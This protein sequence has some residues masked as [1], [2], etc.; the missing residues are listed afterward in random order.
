M[1]FQEALGWMKRGEKIKRAHWK[2]MF[3]FCSSDDKVL[4]GGGYGKS[5]YYQIKNRDLFANDWMISTNNS[6]EEEDDDQS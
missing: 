2:S 4:M 1:T 5:W 6:F 3:I